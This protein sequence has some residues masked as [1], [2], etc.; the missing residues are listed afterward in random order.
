M[1]TTPY[2][3][4]DL[5]I[6]FTKNKRGGKNMWESFLKERVP[7]ILKEYSFDFGENRVEYSPRISEL[8][9]TNVNTR[10]RIS[11]SATL[12]VDVLLKRK[13]NS[14]IGM[15]QLIL[16]NVPLAKFPVMTDNGFIINGTRYTCLN[17]V[18][19]ANGWYLLSDHKS[20]NTEYNAKIL[21]QSG[22]S[23]SNADS[24]EDNVEDD[25]ALT[26]EEVQEDT[27][28]TA[29][30]ESDNAFKSNAAY[31]DVEAD[32]QYN[33]VL[34]GTDDEELSTGD[35]VAR[36]SA[37]TP[38][39][40]TMYSSNDTPIVDTEIAQGRIVLVYKTTF[41]RSLTFFIKESKNKSRELLVL[42][43]SGQIKKYIPLITFLRAIAPDMSVD[44]IHLRFSSFDIMAEA[45]A[46]WIPMS[47]EECAKKI[48]E[49]F[50]A[51][52]GKNSLLGSMN[53]PTDEV[54]SRL[55]Y[56]FKPTPE[57][58]KNLY[59]FM[60][61]VGCRLSQT[62]N[63]SE[64]DQQRLGAHLSD[65]T[66]GAILTPVLLSALDKCEDLTELWVMDPQLN[67]YRV[68]KF[69][70]S[71]NL[72]DNI[73]NALYMYF[74]ALEGVGCPMQQDAF[75]N[76]IVEPFP[77][78]AEASMVQALELFHD[79]FVEAYYVQHNPERLNK[80]EG[81]GVGSHI[82][83]MEAYTK[84]FDLGNLIESEYQKLLNKIRTDAYY[85]TKDDTNSIANFGQK[86]QIKYAIGKE[87]PKAL[88]QVRVDQYGLVCPHS[89]SEGGNVG[90]NLYLTWD[91]EVKG[92]LLKRRF[93]K[94]EHGKRVINE[95]TNAPVEVYLSAGE[96]SRSIIATANLKRPDN[97]LAYATEDCPEAYLGGKLVQVPWTQVDY[98]EI[99]AG[100]N[101]SPLLGTVPF[102]WANGGKRGPMSVNTV[103]QVYPVLQGE[104]PWVDSGVT[105]SEDIGIIRARSFIEYAAREMGDLNYK[106]SVN[107][108]ITICDL[109]QKPEYTAVTYTV[110][111]TGLETL[112]GKVF[113]YTV[114][115]L[116]PTSKL[117]LRHARL[118]Q[119]QGNK[120]SENSKMYYADEIVVYMNDVVVKDMPVTGNNSLVDTKK[121]SEYGVA[122]GHN[123][124]IA[125][126]SM[127]GWGYEDA[128][129]F[130][131]N[132]IGSGKFAILR[133]FS[134]KEEFLDDGKT[135]FKSHLL[136]KNGTL[137]RPGD[138]VIPL[139]ITDSSNKQVPHN[140]TLKQGRKDRGYVIGHKVETYKKDDNRMYK[141]ITVTLLSVENT[142]I[143]DKHTGGHGNKGVI[144]Y[145]IPMQDIIVTEDG[146]VPDVIANPTGV[147]PRNNLGQIIEIVK[148]EL[149]RTTGEIQ[150][151]EPFSELNIDEIL[152]D[153]EAHGLEEK[154]V[155]NPQTGKF[156][157]RKCF[158]GT[159]FF[160]RSEHDTKGKYNA[161]GG[162][163]P[164]NSNTATVSRC[165]GG[166]QRI[167]EQTSWTLMA[168]GVPHVM[169][170]LYGIQGSDLS[171]KST[172]LASGCTTI[173]KQTDNF[174]N[175]LPK[176]YYRMLGEE[177][178]DYD[179]GK[180]MVLT[181]TLIAKNSI[182]ITKNTDI[183]SDEYGESKYT[184]NDDL[185]EA[186]SLMHGRALDM[187]MPIVFPQILTSPFVLNSMVYCDPGKVKHWSQGL[188]TTL[189]VMS[190]LYET[191]IDD[192]STFRSYILDELDDVELCERLDDRFDG[193]I[194]YKLGEIHSTSE[195]TASQINQYLK[196][197]KIRHVGDSTIKKILDG[198][199]YVVWTR[200]SRLP[201]LVTK[202]V[203]MKLDSNFLCKSG[204]V[205]ALTLILGPKYLNKLNCV[206][207]GEASLAIP[208]IRA[209]LAYIYDTRDEAKRTEKHLNPRTYDVNDYLKDMIGFLKRLGCQGDIPKY[210]QILRNFA[211]VEK[212]TACTEFLRTFAFADDIE[213]FNPTLLSYQYGIAGLSGTIDEQ[214]D[215]IYREGT[216]DETGS[217]NISVD[218]HNLILNPVETSRY[219]L[220]LGYKLVTVNYST[221]FSEISS[222]Y[223]YIPSKAYRAEALDGI[224]SQLTKV[225]REVVKV[226]KKYE[227]GEKTDTRALYLGQL[228]AVLTKLQEFCI[229]ELKDHT[230]KTAILR[231]SVLSCRVSWSARG[232]IIGNPTLSIDEVGVPF[233]QGV[234]MF[235]AILNNEHRIPTNSTLA[236]FKDAIPSSQSTWETLIT[237]LVQ[238]NTTTLDRLLCNACPKSTGPNDA[239]CDLYVLDGGIHT[240]IPE[241]YN[242]QDGVHN[243]YEDCRLDL[244]NA[245]NDVLKE[246][247][248]GLERAPSLWKHSNQ[249][250]NGKVVEG[251]AIHLCQ[252]N[253]RAYNADFDGDQMAMYII[254][255]EEGREE[256]RKYMFPSKN[257]TSVKNGEVIPELNQ[258]MALGIYWATINR[259]NREMSTEELL[260]EKPHGFYSSLN[261]VI[262]DYELGLLQVHD[263]I[264]FTTADEEGTEYVYKD[265]VGRIWLN[266]LLPKGLGF[267]TEPLLN[268]ADTNLQVNICKLRTQV[269]GYTSINKDAVKKLVSYVCEV[270]KDYLADYLNKMK[271]FGFDMAT[272]SGVTL[273]LFDFK[274][275]TKHPSLQEDVEAAKRDTKEALTMY[276]LGL[277]THEEYLEYLSERINNA[278]TD[279]ERKLR[280]IVDPYSNIAL[281]IQSGARGSYGQLVELTTMVGLV[282]DSQGDTIPQPIFTG[283]CSG[284]PSKA[285]HDT[286]HTIRNAL[287]TTAISTGSIGEVSRKLVYTM[288]H[289]KIMVEECA[290]DSTNIRI[291]YNVNLPV[292]F[293]LYTSTLEAFNEADTNYTSEL[294][295]RWAQL[296]TDW[297]Q[298]KDTLQRESNFSVS[299][300]LLIE[301]LQ[302]HRIT[303]MKYTTDGVTYISSLKYKMCHDSVELI[304]NR[305]V[306]KRKMFMHPQKYEVASNDLTFH[307]HKLISPHRN[308]IEYSTIQKE[309]I[310]Q[311][312][313]LIVTQIPIYLAVNCQTGICARCYG[314]RLDGGDPIHN[315]MEGIQDGQAIGQTTTQLAMDTHKAGASKQVTSFARVSNIL[316]QHNIGDT[317]LAAPEDGLLVG[318]PLTDTDMI[319]TL[320]T[321]EHLIPLLNIKN[322]DPNL[323]VTCG[324]YVHKGDLIYYNRTVNYSLMFESVKDI[325]KCKLNLILIMAKLYDGVSYR[326][327]DVLMRELLKFGVAAKTCSTD[328]N[329]FVEGAVYLQSELQKNNV[330]FLPIM[331][332]TLK[333]MMLNN[334]SATAQASGYL[335]MQTGQA[336][337]LQYTS[338]ANSPIA[339]QLRALRLS[340]L[341]TLGESGITEAQISEI[342]KNRKY[343]ERINA[344]PSAISNML[345]KLTDKPFV[346]GTTPDELLKSGI[347]IVPVSQLFPTSKGVE[348]TD[349]FTAALEEF[350]AIYGE[351]TLDEIEDTHFFTESVPNDENKDAF[352]DTKSESV[353]FDDTNYFGDH[354]EKLYGDALAV[355]KNIT[356]SNVDEAVLSTNAIADT[357]VSVM[358]ILH[359]NQPVYSQESEI[360]LKDKTTMLSNEPRVISS[361]MDT[362]AFFE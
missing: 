235:S 174:L 301:L 286:A 41:G 213:D 93:Y 191:G 171:A 233:P 275:L 66:E 232:Y 73:F 313:N 188:P 137:L 344:T 319:I 138:T 77:T 258:D 57:M 150:C 155:F 200:M 46:Q 92:N 21:L 218:G 82:V 269:M 120:H 328:T 331:V 251:Y 107:S 90:L 159:M 74:L 281:L 15:N 280:G 203:A 222:R 134:I 202:A 17:E 352:G 112:D 156:L 333:S 209:S 259:Q 289:D 96:I 263:H 217:L 145:V 178:T 127:N 100:Q 244:W 116:T 37:K 261:T 53:A 7:E 43:K 177:F 355:G 196:V 242:C 239:L 276:E 265:T 47:A 168:N 362:T 335:K 226:I 243:F 274:G 183:E 290:A 6:K 14:E 146:V 311:M 192:Y 49:E 282:N 61:L 175:R 292:Q 294:A 44:D 271:N 153:A 181:D 324:D 16:N 223:V 339:A 299:E 197:S 27:L 317:V 163:G 297:A 345:N 4:Y 353:T 2:A 245:L 298:Y 277:K 264:I 249:A 76:K 84:V 162:N 105:Q 302:K 185:I 356:N 39:L 210:I 212:K 97:I 314:S 295:H 262:R 121:V 187:E 122:C 22:K 176:V 89:T 291:R 79:R 279:I 23:D 81:A 293:D 341:Y 20:N 206:E 30:E 205:G 165:R 350:T 247:P 139:Q 361:T 129:V 240:E 118:N 12:S 348:K 68:P 237:A 254:I 71:N 152:A 104:R 154:R 142:D 325:D 26:R 252:L 266:G 31:N 99:H 257:L 246:F 11:P 86:K 169:D 238:R 132:T 287:I 48:L 321:K 308:V 157:D 72:T 228:Y 40:Q 231:D 164:I 186:R 36:T 250:F 320:A 215:L 141:R 230:S 13:D 229:N 50:Y 334:K 83:K 67:E 54:V 318:T 201:F 95:Q 336:A 208:V 300:K 110:N 25:T 106:P 32:M 346:Q 170:S 64:R 117:T 38:K 9:S 198:S 241:R 131:A 307:T 268:K 343:G 323:A 194:P 195:M 85:Q 304:R 330:P 173:P 278:K 360:E 8:L 160:Y 148:A 144:G 284:L 270:A 272:D 135:T 354:D 316:T 214:I 260:C 338:S 19:Q 305:T 172:Y 94:L 10:D 18:R 340:E 58:D 103:K 113:T 91:S 189:A 303:H 315:T 98:E 193:V 182:P 256:Q 310:S 351:N 149:G 59:T 285:Y 227:P 147:L 55:S 63:F 29:E 5:H 357:E 34:H 143:S 234:V 207:G 204:Y 140:I 75:E 161:E 52:K 1:L 288:D 51:V 158:I 45:L 114:P 359:S 88:R 126:M 115:A 273:S 69:V 296:C 125:F 101:V 347:N 337:V 326:H 108:S 87:V 123:V 70:N 253:C 56:I 3:R 42:Y 109:Q 236:R 28:I 309:T 167:G 190:E 312:E 184:N 342:Y 24:P 124:K 267:T 78:K 128:L 327:F 221:F 130:N 332:D 136:P 199:M 306:D 133:N 216:F 322:D 33:E 65:I 211:N 349:A 62:P 224:P 329:Y 283:Y 220:Y 358:G 151:V 35:Y 102:F 180:F 80:I 219:L 255:S 225:L 179:N 119:R 60:R 166:G 248:I 111:G